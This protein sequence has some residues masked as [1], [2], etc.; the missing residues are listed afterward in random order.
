MPDRT[1]LQQK[2]DLLLAG[3]IVLDRKLKLPFPLSRSSAGP[4]VGSLTLIL[5]FANTRVKLRVTRNDGDSPYR[6]V[7]STNDQA[8]GQ[9]TYSI[10]RGQEV[11]LQDVTPIWTPIHALGQAFINID[12]NCRYHCLFCSSPDLGNYRRISNERW[13]RHIR[14][15]AESGDVHSIAI[16]SGIPTT[17]PENIDDFVCILTSVRDLGLAMGVEPY[18]DEKDQLQRLYDAGARELKL[19][20]QSWDR[21]IFDTICPE[22]D[23]DTI[24]DMLGHGVEIYGRNNVCSNLIIGLGESDESVIEGVEDL[25]RMGVAVNLRKLHLNR[26]NEAR[27]RRSLTI[28]PVTS[29]RFLGLREKQKEIFLRHGINTNRFRTM[30]FPCGACDLEV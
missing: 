21:T 16:T 28:E 13:V 6:L 5:A 27:L 23:R 8:T 25:A 19:N 1:I 20:I 30:C 22:L 7:E 11:F 14:K 9:T 15:F 10:M 26:Q 29:E 12:A 2:T 3:T 24:L 17:I 4:E 18:V